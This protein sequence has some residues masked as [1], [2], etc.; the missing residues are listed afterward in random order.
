[1]RCAV[2]SS[3]LIIAIELSYLQVK[4]LNIED[5]TFVLLKKVQ[6]V[7]WLTSNRRPRKR[8]QSALLRRLILRDAAQNE[9]S[10]GRKSRV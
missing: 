1:M 8:F 6:K 4:Y 3:S 9:G 5:K 2:R 10:V 7:L